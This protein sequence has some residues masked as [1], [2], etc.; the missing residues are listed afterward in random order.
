MVSFTAIVTSALA[1]LPG[2]IA[3]PSGLGEAG[4]TSLS[5]R[6]NSP[7]QWWTE[8]SGQ[9]S[10]QQQGG[11][12]YS[13][14]WSG[15]QGGGMVAGTGWGAGR[16]TVKYSGTYNPKGPG[17]LSLYGWT[18]NPLVEYYIVESWDVLAPGEPWTLRGN[19]T[20]QGNNYAFYTAQRVNKPSIE[21][22][23]TFTQYFSVRSE[24]EKKT[25]SVSG[26]INTGDHFDFWASK[27]YRMGN[28]EQNMFFVTEAFANGTKL[29]SGTSTITVS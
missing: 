21:G 10:C 8:G 13:C 9:F 11:G 27:G 18:R 6:Q 20:S 22:S 1:L 23:R 15:Q 26:S 16:K 17:Y 4:V 5:T 19:F 14:S 2:A 25:G 12:K 7:W 3:A 28:F 29:P 24:A